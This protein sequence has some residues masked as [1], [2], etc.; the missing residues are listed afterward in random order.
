MLL[1]NKSLSEPTEKFKEF[2]RELDVK[3]G[4]LE[5]PVSFRTQRCGK[6]HFNVYSISSSSKA[7]QY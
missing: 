2:L 4:F 1:S 3:P 7:Y 6:S 5:D